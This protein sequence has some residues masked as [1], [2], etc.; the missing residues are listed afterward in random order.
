MS[1]EKEITVKING[2]FDKVIEIL[3][4]KDFKIIDKFTLEDIYLI[5]K[6][7]DINKLS[8]REILKKAIIRRNV[9]RCKV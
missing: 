4:D 5:P 6:D 8:V 3:L 1:V 2:G 7:I 9:E